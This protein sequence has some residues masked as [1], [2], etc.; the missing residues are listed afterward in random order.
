MTPWEEA[1][2]LQE[3]LQ[4]GPKRAIEAEAPA[5]EWAAFMVFLGSWFSRLNAPDATLYTVVIVPRRRCCSPLVALG[6]LLASA[7]GEVPDLSWE[8]FALL[9]QDSVVHFLMNRN[10]T[11]RPFK[12]VLMDSAG[13]VPRE[14]K[15]EEEGVRIWIHSRDVFA[16]RHFRV[17]PYPTEHR[18]GRIAKHRPFYETLVPGF[19][20]HWL[21]SASSICLVLANAAQWSHDLE[22]VCV[23]ASFPGSDSAR[24]HSLRDILMVDTDPTKPGIKTLLASPGGFSPPGGRFPVALADGPK[25]LSSIRWVDARNVLVLVDQA[26]YDEQVSGQIVE[27]TCRREDSLVP[28]MGGFPCPLPAGVDLILFAVPGKNR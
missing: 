10:G 12:G 3:R 2:G 13:S 21:V 25:A 7:M 8:E 6:T 11:D 1:L 5:P 17:P 20:N 26:E 14:V 28:P 4:I 18:L 23:R 16:K 19:R 27:M 15:L 9:P 24:P 22:D